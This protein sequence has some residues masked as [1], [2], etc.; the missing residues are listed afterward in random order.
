MTRHTT[1]E[2]RMYVAAARLY[3]AAFRTLYLFPLHS[4][5]DFRIGADFDDDD[6]LGRLSWFPAAYGP[7][8]EGDDADGNAAYGSALIYWTMRRRRPRVLL[9]EAARAIRSELER[10]AG[11]ERLSAVQGEAHRAADAY[12]WLHEPREEARHKVRDLI[13]VAG[14]VY[15]APRRACRAL[16]HSVRRDGVERTRAVLEQRPQTFGP[17][18][19]SAD[20]SWLRV[21]S[22]PT[23]AHARKEE[24]PRFLRVFDAAAAKW[25]KRAKAGLTA[26]SLARWNEAVARAEA[27]RYPRRSGEPLKE[28]ARVLAILYRRR[29]VD[30]T[31]TRGRK[32]PPK[33]EDQ[34][35]VM[36][37]PEA[38]PLIREAIK[39]SAKH[40]GEDPI[41]IR[42]QG[43]ELEVGR[44][45]ERH[46]EGRGLDL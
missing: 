19:R 38:V 40:S 13:H 25:S 7:C 14:H 41:W 3:A 36:L 22:I 30:D 37:P 35:A 26:R 33:V 17:L 31:T 12:A 43:M 10:R 32:L 18:I 46:R 15:D 6:A 28:A 21:V 34:L 5:H 27:V 39:Q 9:W 29:A 4:R 16:L 45:R 20:Y 24:L 11:A 23:T 8:H 44:R 2:R 1:R 42:G